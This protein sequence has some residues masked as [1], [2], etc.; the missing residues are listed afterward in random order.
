MKQVM[1][2]E[3]EYE[4]IEDFNGGFDQTEVEGKLTEY[5]DNYDYIFGDWSYGK[6]RLKGFCE[7]QNPLYKSINDIANKENYL[8]DNCSY[9]CRYFVLKKSV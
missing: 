9:G 8:L 5:F 6:L 7:K 4:L 2:N 1:I 3:H